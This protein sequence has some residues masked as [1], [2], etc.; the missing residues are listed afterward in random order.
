MAASQPAAL[1]TLEL[2]C[3]ELPPNIDLHDFIKRDAVLAPIV[4]LGGAGRRMRRHLAGFLECAAVLEVGGD[5]RA[6]ES[7]V[8]DLCR[9][10]GLLGAPRVMPIGIERTQRSW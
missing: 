6:A 10:A 7:V 1:K 2:C 4:E 8:A 5:P 3:D 9:D